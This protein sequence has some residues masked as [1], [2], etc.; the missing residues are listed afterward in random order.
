MNIAMHIYIAK[1]IIKWQKMQYV[2]LTVDENY[3][4]SEELS[5]S[6]GLMLATNFFNLNTCLV[7]G[8]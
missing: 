6:V 8:L 1:S 7:A 3:F 5:Y 4:I 2:N